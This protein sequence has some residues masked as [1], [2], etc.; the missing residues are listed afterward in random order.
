MRWCPECGTG[1]EDAVAACPACRVVLVAEPPEPG[2]ADAPVVI[3]RVPDP[4]SG[5]LLNGILLQAGFH[6]V[7]R[8]SSLPAYGIVGRDWGTTHWGELLVPRGES[9][10]ARAAIADYLAALER[11]GLVRDEDVEGS[12]PGE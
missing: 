7:L 5:A 4:A 12:P 2:E 9:A 3:H 8:T 11:G 6:A 1:Y 10:D